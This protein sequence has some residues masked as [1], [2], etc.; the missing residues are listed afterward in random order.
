MRGRRILCEPGFVHSVL[1]EARQ[2]PGRGNLLPSRGWFY[3]D[4]YLPLAD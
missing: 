2:S 1:A 3:G 4:P